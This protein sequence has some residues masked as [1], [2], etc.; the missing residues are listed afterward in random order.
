MF[1]YRPQLAESN[2]VTDLGDLVTSNPRGNNCLLAS[3]TKQTKHTTKPVEGFNDVSRFTWS[4]IQP[5][6]SEV[7]VLRQRKQ[8]Q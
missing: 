5:H 3:L 6:N 2:L 4:T 1:C 8:Q 7:P